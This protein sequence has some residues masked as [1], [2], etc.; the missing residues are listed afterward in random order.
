VKNDASEK[1][2]SSERKRRFLH[3]SPSDWFEAVAWDLSHSI[4]LWSLNS[5]SQLQGTK[6]LIFGVKDSFDLKAR[7]DRLWLAPNARSWKDDVTSAMYT[8]IKTPPA[9][10]EISDY[11]WQEEGVTYHHYQSQTLI[12][13]LHIVFK[14]SYLKFSDT[15][16][17]QKTGT[18]MGISPAPPWFFFFYG[19]YKVKLL[20]KW[21]EHVGF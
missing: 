10:A 14:H 13:A 20:S 8:Y 7:L 5:C 6:S 12:D 4:S 16:W 3:R 11:L 19:L 21:K 15:Y 2:N 1:E 18:V 17:C 9:L